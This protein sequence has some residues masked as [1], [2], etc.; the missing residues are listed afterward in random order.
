MLSLQLGPDPIDNQQILTFARIQSVDIVVGFLQQHHVT[1]ASLQR[2]YP[3]GHVGFGAILN[4]L[5][6]RPLEGKRPPDVQY[7]HKCRNS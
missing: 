6:R 4:P 5:G 3:V 1:K 2:R 7:E